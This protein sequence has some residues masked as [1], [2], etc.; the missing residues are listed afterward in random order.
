M[1]QCGLPS[2]HTKFHLSAGVL[3]PVAY[4]AEAASWALK[5]AGRLPLSLSPFSVRMLLINRWF[6]V[7]KAARRLG[8]RPAVAYAEAWPAAVE[9]VRARLVAAGELP[10]K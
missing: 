10:A 9:A 4:A 2:L 8:Y 7:G 6:D 3:Y 5:A 1:T